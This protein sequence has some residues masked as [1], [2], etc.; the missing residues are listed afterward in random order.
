[1]TEVNANG[2]GQRVRHFRTLRG[3]SQKELAGTVDR[4]H[5]M[6]AMIEQGRRQIHVDELVKFAWALNVSPMALIGGD[7]A[8]RYAEGYAAGWHE[9]LKQV[10]RSLRGLLDLPEANPRQQ[11]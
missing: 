11:V 6:V 5:S 4:S 9:A 8:D 7:E 10:H 2:F 1:M 3:I